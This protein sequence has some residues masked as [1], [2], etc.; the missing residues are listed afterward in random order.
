MT[1]ILILK[2]YKNANNTQSINYIFHMVNSL[3]LF[4]SIL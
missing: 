2:F 4:L 3:L 1:L